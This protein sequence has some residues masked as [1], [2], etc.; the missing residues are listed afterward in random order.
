LTL[1]CYVFRLNLAKIHEICLQKLD[2]KIRIATSGC[3]RNEP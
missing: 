3:G 2:M 1:F